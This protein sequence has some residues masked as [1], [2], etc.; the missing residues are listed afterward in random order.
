MASNPE[1]NQTKVAAAKA[2]AAALPAT[3]RQEIAK[4]A[5]T[6]RWGTK[7]AKATHAGSFKEKFGVDVEC[8]VLDDTTKTAV[9]SQTGLARLLGMSP[10]G[11]SFPSFINSRAMAD[12]VG[13][14][15]R[16]KIEN[17]FKFQA[18]VG[19]G[20]VPPVAVHGFDTA[21]LIDVCNAIIAAEAAQKLKAERYKKIIAQAHIIVGASAKQGI[22]GLVYA[23]AGYNPST[24]EVIDA[25]KLYVMEEAKKYE[26][27][28]PNELYM[29]WHRLYNIPILERGKPWHFKHL[30][31]RHVY[32]PLAQSSGK[33]LTLLRALKAKDGNR[34]VKLFQFLNDVGA[35]ALR[36]HMGR[37]L[38]M[39][40]S[41][42]DSQTYERRIAERFG[43]QKELD[44]VIPSASPTA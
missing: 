19:G 15:L 21:L 10:R 35:R 44:L 8:Y 25:F 11:N 36:I 7:P 28:F 32:F 37:V 13:G 43:E 38:E 5:A 40:E 31:V 14:E 41:S 22:R 2:R 18:S 16:E 4:K 24:E 42:K 26:S 6:T 29:E 20:G 1:K 27:E 9:I 17:P 39:A 12:F 3:R 34:K 33:I 23:L 30:T